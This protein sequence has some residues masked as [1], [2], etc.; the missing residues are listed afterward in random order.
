MR[1]KQLLALLLIFVSALTYAQQPATRLITGIVKDENGNFLPGIT[2]A[3]N[4]TAN[5]VIANEKGA[6]LISV[7]E[8]ASLK[9]T[10]VGFESQTINIDNKNVINITLKGES[11]GLGEIVV[12]GYGT[13]K[14]GN[15]TG[16]VSVVK[17]D[18]LVNRPTATVSQALQGKVPG[19]NFSAGSYGF[20]PG[21]ALSMQIRGQGSP[22]ILVD[23]IYTSNINGLNPNDIESVTVLKDAAAAAIYGAF[24]QNQWSELLSF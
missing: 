18:E 1:S 22:L 11:K 4:A 21:A 3:E 10:G 5:S 2:V 6:F 9:F 24:Y 17:G 13:Q 23:G 15:L 7:K 14:K 20:E 8:N 19:M 16:A 12:V